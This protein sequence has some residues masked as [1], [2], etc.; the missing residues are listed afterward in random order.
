M[1][2]PGCGCLESAVR[3]PGFV[4]HEM[5]PNTGEWIS[6]EVRENELR[7][8]AK[9]VELLASSERIPTESHCNRRMTAGAR[10]FSNS[11]DTSLPFRT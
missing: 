10:Q 7:G 5:R 6:I 2:F 11:T 3:V 9:R 4:L 1:R 8:F